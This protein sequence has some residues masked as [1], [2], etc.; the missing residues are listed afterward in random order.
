MVHVNTR[1]LN[2]STSTPLSLDVLAVIDGN[3]NT[4]QAL[5]RRFA[6]ARIRGEWFRPVPELLAHIAEIKARST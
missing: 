5:H 1:V 2:L 3:W 4:E 6:R